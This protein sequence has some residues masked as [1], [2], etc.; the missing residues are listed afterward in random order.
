MAYNVHAKLY[1]DNRKQDD[2]GQMVGEPSL[3]RDV[4]CEA[5][6][7]GGSRKS[8]AGRLVADY[9]VVLTTRWREGIEQC[10][11]VEVDGEMHVI[12]SIVPEGRK[13]KVHIAYGKDGID[14]GD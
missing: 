10:A 14:Y 6:Y 4:W 9:G 5:T 13:Y 8:Y 1:I 2:F 3:W 7:S 11:F 12:D